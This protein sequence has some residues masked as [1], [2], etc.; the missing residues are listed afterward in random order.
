MNE[1]AD[2]GFCTYLCP[3]LP[4]KIVGVCVCVI[5]I[6]GSRLISEAGPSVVLSKSFD[7]YQGSCDVAYPLV[8][9]LRH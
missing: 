5:K 9:L 8:L 3:D 1:D 7:V 2:L 6:P 4:A